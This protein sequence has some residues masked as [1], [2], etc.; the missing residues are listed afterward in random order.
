[1][2]LRNFLTGIGLL[3]VFSVQ[4]LFAQQTSAGNSQTVQ[5]PVSM[6][7]PG[8]W[9]NYPRT[10]GRIVTA[11]SR[12]DSQQWQTAGLIAAATGALFLVD[13]DIR[14]W[15]QDDVRSSTTDDMANLARPFGSSG[16]VAV[17][18]AAIYGAGVLFDDQRIQETGLLS[19]Q[20]FVLSQVTLETIKQL[21]HR[22][23][24]SENPGDAHQWDGPS[25]KS[26]HKSFAS[27]HAA[28][29][30]MLAGV[31]SSE[32]PDNGPLRA[33]VYG[34]ASLTAISRVNDDRHWASDIVAGAAIGYGIG[35]LVYAMSPFHENGR[36]T[37]QP[38]TGP[39]G[40][41]LQMAYR[42]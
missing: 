25:L 24:P 29:A 35:K 12:W 17:G 2:L 16:I 42:F 15:W 38:V 40:Y 6:S 37:L 5:S 27:G 36:T 20:G 13:E 3:M 21:A 32:S 4:P 7:N 9:E 41:G 23:R 1:M 22:Q 14:D 33:A 8:Y 10:L 19:L 18:S 11:P 31:V 39:D 30:F 26:G 34:I 28:K